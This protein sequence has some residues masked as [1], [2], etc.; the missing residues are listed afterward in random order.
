M[1]RRFLAGLILG[2]LAISTE[3]ALA[4]GQLQVRVSDIQTGSFPQIDLFL[5]VFDGSGRRVPALPA[6]AFTVLEDEVAVTPD[7]LQETLVGTRQVFV[8]DTSAGLGLRD[9]HGRSR[10]DFVRTAF[11]EWWRGPAASLYGADDLTLLTSDGLLVDHSRSAAELAAALADHEPSFSDRNPDLDTLFQGL[12]FASDPA[13]G[14]GMPAAVIFVTPGASDLAPA[15]LEN[16]LG[17]AKDSQI[18]VHMILVGGSGAPGAG[19]L[20]LLA[21]ETGGSLIRFDPESG[22]AGLAEH[23]LGQRAQ[24]HLTYSSRLQT[25]GEHRVQVRVA[26]ENREA[27]SPEAVFRATVLP[28]AV[29]FVSPPSR[30]VR[31]TEDPAVSIEAIPPTSRDLAVLVTFPDGYPRSITQS[32]LLVDGEI[33][34]QR[35][36][37]PYDRFDWDLTGFRVTAHH[38]IQAVVWDTLGL[39]GASEALSVQLQVEPAPGGLLALR[40]AI[41][42]LLASFVLLVAGLGA[43]TRILALGT[44]SRMA[45]RRDRGPGARRSRL[46]RAGMRRPIAAEPEAWLAPEDGP[47]APEPFALAGLD[48]ILGRDPSFASLVVED[49]SVSGLH[50]AVIRQADGEY[51]IRDQGSVAGTWVNFEPVPEAGHRLKHGDL[52]HLGRVAFRFR[53]ARPRTA[54]GIRVVSLDEPA[55][56]PPSGQETSG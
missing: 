19:P 38:T 22:L 30:I 28:P 34:D 50:A 18:V 16:A 29:T 24:Y 53:L 36:E 41:L 6:S 20:L 47:A 1:A 13:P 32:Q 37:A 27:A 21:Q 2:T 52:I 39:Q 55:V 4:Q 51:L 9:S 26:A 17:R 5:S 25:A 45:P 49:P 40:H 48:V 35:A 3:P 31:R 46:R 42:P 11:L 23:I 8:L 12:T 54:R 33:A 56:S 43:A 15:A 14:P 44:A 7:R 10:F